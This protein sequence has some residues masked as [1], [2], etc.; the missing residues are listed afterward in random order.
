L[1]Q[2]LTRVASTRGVPAT[3][4]CDSDTEFTSRA[5]DQWAYANRVALDFS[6]PGKPTDNATIE[7]FNAR[8]RRERPSEHYFS[9]LADAHIVLARSRDEYN[10][11]RPHSSFG[12][13]APAQFRAGMEINADSGQQLRTGYL[14]WC[15]VGSRTY[16]LLRIAG[17]READKT[18]KNG[19]LDPQ[20]VRSEQ[21]RP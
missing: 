7:S 4:Q 9:T 13:P 11:H 5:L 15:G 8:V 10:N 12:Q 1:A 2:I 20:T 14:E 19:R 3:I 18:S 21:E 6:R 16:R 17:G